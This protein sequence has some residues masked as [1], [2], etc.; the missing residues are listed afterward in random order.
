MMALGQMSTRKG[1]NRENA[2]LLLYTCIQPL[3]LQADVQG[4]Q[5][6]VRPATTPEE[7]SRIV[8]KA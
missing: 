4:V 2:R 8:E 5:Q 3:L 1:P 7:T 6:A